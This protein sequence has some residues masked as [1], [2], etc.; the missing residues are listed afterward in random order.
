[1]PLVQHDPQPVHLQQRTFV[2][3][4]PL[5]AQAV[6]CRQHDVIVPRQLVRRGRPGVLAIPHV[7]LQLLRGGVL[8]NLGKFVE[9]DVRCDCSRTMKERNEEG[10]SWQC[11]STRGPRR[12]C[13]SRSGKGGGGA[14]L[15]VD[16]RQGIESA[17]ITI[18][19]VDLQR[20]KGGVLLDLR[21]RMKILK[22]L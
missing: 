13:A 15:D 8:L 7:D 17:G 9:K 10:R 18:Q 19:H 20:F 22:D 6:E 12:G 1:M 16:I 21:K 11:H 3:V 14:Q 5:R 4:C 2:L